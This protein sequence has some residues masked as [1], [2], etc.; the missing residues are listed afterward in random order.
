MNLLKLFFPIPNL[1]NL[2]LEPSPPSSDPGKLF[3]NVCCDYLIIFLLMGPIGTGKSTFINSIRT[4]FQGYNCASAP[5]SSEIADGLG[6]DSYTLQLRSH[7]LRNGK[8]GFLPFVMIDTM[9]VE[10]GDSNGIHTDDIVSTLQGRIKDGYDFNPSAAIREKDPRYNHN[11]TMKDKIHCLVFVLPADKISM[12]DDDILK[13]MKTVRKRAR[14]AGIPQV[15]I[16]TMVDKACPLVKDDLKKIYT[17]KKIKKKMEECSTKVGV[18][19]N[20]I[21]PIKCYSEEVEPQ[22]EIDALILMALTNMVNFANDYVE[23]QS[24]EEEE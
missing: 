21:F 9:G 7:K 14:D 4:T 24:E 17:S 18:P 10:A 2:N 20:Y 15:V 5:S 16:M 19:M 3:L 6:K 23:D 11:P 8:D 13:K 1:S 12:V 22:V